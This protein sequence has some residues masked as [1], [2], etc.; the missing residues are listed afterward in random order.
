[1]TENQVCKYYDCGWCYYQ[2]LTNTN[3]DNGACNGYRFC[4]AY[5]PKVTSNIIARG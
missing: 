3:S 1:M 5:E 4:C 2:G